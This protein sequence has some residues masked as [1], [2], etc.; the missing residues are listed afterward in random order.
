[1]EATGRRASDLRGE[2]KAPDR[3]A[4]AI[5]GLRRAPDDL[6]ARID[7]RTAEMARAGVVDEVRGLLAG[8]A[9]VSP[10][11]AQAIGFAEV[12]EHI[13]GRLDLAACLERI[14]RATRRF[15]KKQATFFR[16]FDVSWVDVPADE[17]PEATAVRVR[18][19]LAR[20]GYGT[21]AA[22]TSS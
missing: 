6:A 9:P 17:A 3:V 18:E 10:E 7:R 12:R 4:V 15:A 2:W 16:R 21:G 19:A 22:G 20:A 1:V 13:E 8:T 5:A 11:L 14:A